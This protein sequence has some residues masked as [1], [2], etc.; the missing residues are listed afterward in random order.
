MNIRNAILVA[1]QLLSMGH[2]P[3]VPHLTAFWHFIS[4]KPWETW[5][6][7]DAAFLPVCDA[8]LRLDGE[9]RGGDTEVALAEKLGIPV[10]YSL[11][12]IPDESE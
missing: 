8:V 7:L 9:S 1:D 10:Y 6:R 4:P 3:F 11:E 2:F 12:D 5:L